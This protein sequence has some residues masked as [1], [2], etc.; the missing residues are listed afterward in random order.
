[1]ETIPPG[2]RHAPAGAMNSRGLAWVAQSKPI[3]R[4]VGPEAYMDL[5]PQPPVSPSVWKVLSPGALG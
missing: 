5:K 1:M 2:S 4:L 3:R